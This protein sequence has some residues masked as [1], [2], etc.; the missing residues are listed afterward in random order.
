M[1]S[2]SH[3]PD[4]RA[5][6]SPTASAV[7]T[8]AFRGS[9]LL[10]IILTLMLGACASAPKPQ[11]FNRAAHPDIRDIAVVPMPAIEVDV[12]MM[13]HPGM[14]F[15]L[16]G[17]LIALGDL[18][19]KRSDVQEITEAAG[20]DPMQLFRDE[21]DATLRERGYTTTWAVNWREERPGTKAAARAALG[22]SVAANPT[23]QAHLQVAINFVGYAAAGA[24]DA[25]PYRPTVMISAEL[26][27]AGGDVVLFRDQILYHNVI[28]S[29]TAIV[30]E[31]SPDY[32]YPD[33]GA[34]QKDGP[35]IVDGLREAVRDS[36]RKLGAQL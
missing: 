25:Q 27:D 11:A 24:G 6:R 10:L 13:N 20:F 28:G 4:R 22:R 31:P 12:T 18:A 29:Q 1:W 5:P 34:L 32:V 17:G 30:L 16:V 35:R 14:N 26:L 2:D 19:A 36:A 33:F 23:S 3:A 9:R 15:G 7:P 8:R 21:L